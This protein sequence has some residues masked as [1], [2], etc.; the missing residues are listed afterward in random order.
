MIAAL[1][2]LDTWTITRLFGFLSLFFFTLSLA[3][4]VIARIKMFKRNKGLSIAIHMSSAW[5][6]IFSVLIHML[7][8][9]ID[10][11]KP[12]SLAGIFIPFQS[13]DNTL[14]TTLGIFS[15]YFFL[16]VIISSD[17]L[18]KVLKRTLWKKIHYLVFPA[19][20]GMFIHGLWLG[21]DTGELWAL[22]FYAVVI[23]SLLFLV[24]FKLL[25]HHSLS[26]K[27]KASLK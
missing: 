12:F 20:I 2:Q 22:T 3:F 8:L 26:S 4:G 18:I 6:G 10:T 5:A 14:A 24:C 27:K 13:T 7:I 16:I 15:F 1:Q 11:Y 21:T 19:W 25:D 17:L 9:L 23:T